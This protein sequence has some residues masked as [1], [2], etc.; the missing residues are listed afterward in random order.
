MYTGFDVVGATE[1]SS[2]VVCNAVLI[3]MWLP[4]VR[5]SCD[6]YTAVKI[7]TVSC[8]EM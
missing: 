3:G 2:V 5:K 7:D 8:S 6:S 4:L 1:G